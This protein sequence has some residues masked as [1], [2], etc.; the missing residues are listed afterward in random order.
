MANIGQVDTLAGVRVNVGQAKTELSKLLAAVEAG[1]HV[2]IAR[3]GVPIVRL[4]KIESA[5]GPGERF[6]AARGALRGRIVV[7]PDF[8]Y[9]EDELAELLG[10]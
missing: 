9:T 10:E 1:E 3:D 5:P 7:E 8:E 2:E 4:V 6:L